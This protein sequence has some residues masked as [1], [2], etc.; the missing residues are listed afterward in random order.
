MS[1]IQSM[2]MANEEQVLRLKFTA[3]NDVKSFP[4]IKGIEVDTLSEIEG[5]LPDADALGKY[6]YLMVNRLNRCNDGKEH[7]SEEVKKQQRAVFL[8]VKSMSSLKSISFGEQIKIGETIF[9]FLAIYSSFDTAKN[10]P[11][12]ILVL[13]SEPYQFGSSISIFSAMAFQYSAEVLKIDTTGPILKN[14]A[15]RLNTCQAADLY[16]KLIEFFVTEGSAAPRIGKA[17]ARQAI[18]AQ[19][20][21][22]RTHRPGNFIVTVEQEQE[23]KLANSLAKK[24]EKANKRKANA[25]LPCSSEKKRQASKAT[26]KQLRSLATAAAIPAKQKV[27]V[28]ATR[29]KML[30]RILDEQADQRSQLKEVRERQEANEKDIAA[31]SDLVKRLAEGQLQSQGVVAF[32]GTSMKELTSLLNGSMKIVTGDIAREKAQADLKISTLEAEL[33]ATSQQLKND[34][35]L[36]VDHNK[37]ISSSLKTYVEQQLAD[38]HQQQVEQHEHHLELMGATSKGPGRPKGRTNRHYFAPMYGNHPFGYNM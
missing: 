10:G 37:F 36:V 26:V 15:T 34:M 25:E 35:K 22:M 4:E 12:T 18:V 8:G 13:P 6:F 27:D 14:V 30:E 16:A 23:R 38:Q 33:Q 1:D 9:Y 32:L 31:Q 17:C 21:A 19:Q 3:L 5:L 24:T 7:Q 29:D 28:T 2:E 20:E 11:M